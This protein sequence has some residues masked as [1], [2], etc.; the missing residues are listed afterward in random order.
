MWQ[1]STVEGEWSNYYVNIVPQQRES[2]NG[3]VSILKKIKTKYLQRTDSESSDHFKQISQ[4][5]N[6]LMRLLREV[7]TRRSLFDSPS[8]SPHTLE[9]IQTSYCDSSTHLS[10]R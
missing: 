7:E 6:H 2:S 1:I 8:L 3:L 4:S 5:Q 9:I 10:T